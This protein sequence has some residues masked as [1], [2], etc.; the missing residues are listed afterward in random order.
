MKRLGAMLVALVS[1]VLLAGCSVS[2]NHTENLNLVQT[3]VVLQE[4]N[5][6]IVKTV[7]AEASQAYI[8]GIG[9][10]SRKA[11]RDNAVA[12]LTEKARLTG[13]QALINVTVKSDVQ[14]I[15]FWTKTTMRAYGTVVEF[16]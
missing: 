11:L 14:V 2:S 3:N 6:H 16:E 10:M 15:L 8:F 5:F 4:D 13:S 1:V 9:G 12:E 7:T